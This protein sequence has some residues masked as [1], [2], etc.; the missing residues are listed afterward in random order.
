MRATQVLTWGARIG[1]AGVVGVLLSRAEGCCQTRRGSL[2]LQDG[3]GAK[4][5][6]QDVPAVCHEQIA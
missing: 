1:A 2:P 6:Q 5:C 3:A 4:V